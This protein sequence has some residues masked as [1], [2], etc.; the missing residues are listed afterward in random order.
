LAASFIIAAKEVVERLTN[1]ISIEV[2]IADGTW[3][4]KS[5]IAEEL[6]GR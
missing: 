4:Q 2:E 1:S 5:A 3:D 6:A